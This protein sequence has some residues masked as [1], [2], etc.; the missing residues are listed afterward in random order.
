MMIFMQPMVQ[1]SSH[2]SPNTEVSVQGFTLLEMLITI[3]LLVTGVVILLQV[4]SIGM[5]SDVNTENSL[6]ALRLAQEKIEEVKDATSYAQ[7][8][9]FAVSRANLGGDFSDFD[10]Q[11][12]VTSD[13]KEVNVSV[14]WDIRGQEQSVLLTSLFADYD[15]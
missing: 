1:D 6:I 11:V 3:V 12:T 2:H 9:T 14:F 8:D 10:R 15:Y 5:F 13:P 4:M 7:I